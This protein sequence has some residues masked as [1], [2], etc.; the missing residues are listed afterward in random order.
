MFSRLKLHKLYG[1]VQTCRLTQIT[2]II[3]YDR[4]QPYGGRVFIQRIYQ[5]LKFSQ[6]LE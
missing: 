5:P 4:F 3:S 1:Q 6:L 2:S